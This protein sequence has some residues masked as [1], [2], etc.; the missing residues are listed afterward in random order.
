MI[1]NY[2]NRLLNESMYVGSKASNQIQTLKVQCKFLRLL[3]TGI[4]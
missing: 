1:D 4:I 2:V 3:K